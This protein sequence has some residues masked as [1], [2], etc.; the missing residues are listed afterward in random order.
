LSTDESEDAEL[1]FVDGSPE[2]RFGRVTNTTGAEV[3]GVS[4]LSQLRPLSGEPPYPSLG[5]DLLAY[6]M[7]GAVPVCIVLICTGFVS[8]LSRTVKDEQPADLGTSDVQMDRPRRS[9]SAQEDSSDEVR[10]L[11]IREFSLDHHR[12]LPSRLIIASEFPVSIAG[13]AARP[14]HPIG[15]TGGPG[16]E[17][18][19]ENLNEKCPI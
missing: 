10:I 18:V 2:S 5:P 13:H 15:E 19:P 4:G 9:L 6:A 1:R 11:K 8:V 14:D 12:V 3:V 16:S 17:I 7:L